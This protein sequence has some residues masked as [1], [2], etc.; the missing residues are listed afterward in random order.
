MQ[1]RLLIIGATSVLAHETA[2]LFACENASFALIARNR[3]KSLRLLPE[4]WRSVALRRFHS[5]LWILRRLAFTIP[6]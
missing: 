3:K 6:Y 2:K 1:E 5:S 4:V